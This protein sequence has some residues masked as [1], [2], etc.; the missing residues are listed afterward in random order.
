[1]NRILVRRVNAIVV[2]G[3][4]AAVVQFGQPDGVAAQDAA[5]IVREIERALAEGNAN[6]LAAVAADRVEVG[7]LEGST[8]YSRSQALYVLEDFFEEFA[9]ERCALRTVDESDTDWFVS[10]QYWHAGGD[11]PLRVF[12]QFKSEGGQ[13]SLRGLRVERP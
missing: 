4:L 2:A 9:P 10:G 8:L 1:M 11:E 3:L 12:V 5:S 6:R 13:W 7:L